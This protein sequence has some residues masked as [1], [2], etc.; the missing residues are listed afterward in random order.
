[1]VLNYKTG[2]KEYFYDESG[3]W[4]VDTFT[5]SSSIAKTS[6]LFN[7]SPLGWMLC[8]KKEL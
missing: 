2:D 5:N 1:M 7:F 3:R 4:F 8:N 6:E